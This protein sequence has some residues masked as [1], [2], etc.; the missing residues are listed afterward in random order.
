MHSKQKPKINSGDLRDLSHA[1][2]IYFQLLLLEVN[3]QDTEWV[4][5]IA[6]IFSDKVRDLT[7]CHLASPASLQ[8]A[9]M[10]IKLTQAAEDVHIFNP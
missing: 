5:R 9:R 1:A 10:V 4:L 7:H 6:H 8:G 3:V 2:S